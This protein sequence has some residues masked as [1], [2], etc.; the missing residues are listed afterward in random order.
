MT[1]IVVNKHENKRQRMTQLFAACRNCYMLDDRG[2]CKSMGQPILPYIRSGEPFC[3]IGRHDRTRQHVSI[4]RSSVRQ[5]RNTRGR[6]RFVIKGGVNLA[7]YVL[8][9]CRADQA[10]QAQRRSVCN[11]CEHRRIKLRIIPVCGLCRCV[12]RA[13]TGDA[14]AACPVQKWTKANEPPR[15]CWSRSKLPIIGRWWRSCGNCGGRNG[16]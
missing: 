6:I 10:L 3:P 12:L 13:K 14:D 8:R 2:S 7:W 11:A 5:G 9:L 16:R 1:S 4:I 15:R